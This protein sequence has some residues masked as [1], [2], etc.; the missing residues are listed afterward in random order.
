MKLVSNN[1]FALGNKDHIEIV[2]IPEHNQQQQQLEKVKDKNIASANAQA[3]WN[4]VKIPYNKRLYCALQGFKGASYS[5][6]DDDEFVPV[7]DGPYGGK[8]STL[9]VGGHVIIGTRKTGLFI[10]DLDTKYKRWFSFPWGTKNGHCVFLP[11]EHYTLLINNGRRLFLHSVLN[12]RPLIDEIKL[13]DGSRMANNATCI[14]MLHKP[15]GDTGLFACAEKKNGQVHFFKYTVTTKHPPNLLGQQINRKVSYYF[16]VKHI[17]TLQAHAKESNWIEMKFIGSGCKLL[18]I[19]DTDK[20]AKVWDYSGLL[21]QNKV[22]TVTL[23]CSRVFAEDPNASSLVNGDLYI[24]TGTTIYKTMC[25]SSNDKSDD[26]LCGYDEYFA[27]NAESI[28]K[29]H[30]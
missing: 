12:G 10:I 5:Y 30:E 7:E 28:V 25:N 27:S 29:K 24:A 14:V 4:I 18:T 1:E 15:S 17:Y 20:C 2:T 3:V 8:P 22:P 16:E 13:M 21:V 6:E 11:I 26:K 9:C 23:V 19:C